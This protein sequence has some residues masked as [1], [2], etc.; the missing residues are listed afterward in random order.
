[1]SSCCNFLDLHDAIKRLQARLLARSPTMPAARSVT[2]ACTREQGAALVLRHADRPAEHLDLFCE[3]LGI[4]RGGLQFMLDRHRNPR[5]WQQRSPGRFEPTAALDA[6]ARA[7][8]SG[9]GAYLDAATARLAV[10]GSAAAS[11]VPRAAATSPSARATRCERFPTG[12]RHRR[13]AAGAA[14][15]DA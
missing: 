14:T 10:R 12:Q 6:G 11:T 4:D 3:W 1:M 7:A 5:Y 15:T 13:P 8:L 9:A 2:G